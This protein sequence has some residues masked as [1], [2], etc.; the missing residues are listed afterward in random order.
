[1]YV[2]SVK[3]GEEQMKKRLLVTMLAFQ[4][5]FTCSPINTVMAVETDDELAYEDSENVDSNG[6]EWDGDK[7]V[8]YKGNKKNVVIPEGTTAIGYSA[9]Y[10]LDIES[11]VIPSTVTDIESIAFSN[12]ENLY[13]VE[14]KS[15]ELNCSGGNI[16]SG[17]SKLKNIRLTGE[18]TSI[19]DG[20]FSDV[21]SLEQVNIPSTVTK[22]GNSAFWGCTSLK[23]INLPEILTTIGENA[24]DSCESL[25]NLIIPKNVDSIGD[26]AFND[27]KGLTE[28]EIKSSYLNYAD[29]IFYDCNNLKKILLTGALTSIPKGMFA[30]IASLESIKLPET[31]SKIGDSAFEGCTSLKTVD[32]PDCVT[33]MGASAFSDCSSLQNFNLPSSLEEIGCYTFLNCT[34][35]TSVVIPEGITEIQDKAYGGCTGLTYLE[36][37]GGNLYLTGIG[38]FKDCKNLKN[39]KL[40]GNLEEIPESLFSYAS[41]LEHVNIPASVKEICRDAFADCTALKSIELPNGLTRIEQ[42]AFYNCSSITILDIP[43]TVTNIDYQTFYGMTGLKDVYIRGKEFPTFYCPFKPVDS[44]TIH[45]YPG[46]KAEQLAKENK[47]NY[48]YITDDDSVKN[49]LTA[50]GSALTLTENIKAKV[51]VALSLDIL[52]DNGAKARITYPDG[53]FKD[54]LLTDCETVKYNNESVKEISYDS[55]PAKISEQVNICVIKSD[56]TKSNSYTFAPTDYL[57]AC[58]NQSLPE[59]GIAKALLNYGAYAQQY[60]GVNTSNLANNKLTDNAVGALSINEV[61][62]ST[63]A[64]NVASLHNADLEYIGSSLVCKSGTDMKIYFRNKN[65]LSLSQLTQKYAFDANYNISLDG[66]ILCLRINCLYPRNLS[67]TYSVTITGAKETLGGTVSPLSYIRKGVQSSDTKLQNLCKAMY[68]YNKE[69]VKYSGV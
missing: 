56:G 66:S 64:E 60:F 29:S 68:L 63:K 49:K 59:A 69:A 28:V 55:V 7:I 51:Y 5:L 19:P 1:M 53:S 12:C 57:Y 24:F 54:I 22:I 38:I 9:F 42:G 37:K 48:V 26:Y 18:L 21:S 45:C 16:F 20:L 36:I 10:N 6:F 43:A 3:E 34:S 39:I 8:S 4:M 17:C 31:V 61:L 11:V 32:M 50:K 67:N 27:C 35:L 46:S 23:Q 2:K 47:I 15:N 25:T 13:S 65:G 40:S 41:Y 58:I 44:L 30:H 52:K 14:I 33:S 62:Q